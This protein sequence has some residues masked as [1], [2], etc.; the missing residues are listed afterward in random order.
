M[1]AILL[2]RPFKVKLKNVDEPCPKVNE[3]LIHVKATCICGSDLHAYRGTHPF[4]VPPVILGHE[5]AGD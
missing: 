5:M 3:V 1:K 4:R 2:E